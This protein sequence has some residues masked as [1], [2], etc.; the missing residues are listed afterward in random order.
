M[1]SFVVWWLRRLRRLRQLARPPRGGYGGAH[2]CRPEMSLVA[3]W[4]KAFALTALFEIAVAAPMLARQEPRLWRRAALVFFA[5]LVS[6]PSVWFVF[7]ELPFSY[8][9]TTAMA[10][11]WALASEVLFYVTVLPGLGFGRAL[12]VSALANGGSFGLGL[13]LWWATGWP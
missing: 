1:S 7:P 3:A 4:S 13:F 9:V 12:A 11:I 6:H 8:S 2:G 10:E 5:Q